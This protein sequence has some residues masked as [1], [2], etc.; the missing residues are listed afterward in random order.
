MLST[1]ILQPIRTNNER[2]PNNKK[3]NTAAIM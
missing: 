1:A 2:M 3:Q